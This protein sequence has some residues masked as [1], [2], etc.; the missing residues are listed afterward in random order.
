MEIR[1]AGEARIGQKNKPA[2]RWAIRAHGPTRCVNL[3][4][5]RD[6]AQ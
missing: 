2:R 6:I 4:F 1:F 5:R 3:Y